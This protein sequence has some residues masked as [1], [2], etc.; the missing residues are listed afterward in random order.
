MGLFSRMKARH[1]R[2]RTRRCPAARAVMP[3]TAAPLRARHADRAALPRGH[4]SSPWSGLG[5]FW[6]A[7]R[8]FWQAEGV[9]T[10]AVG[11]AGGLHAQPDLRGGLLR[12]H[13]AQRGRARGVRPRGDQLRD[14]PARSSGRATTPPR[15]CGRA[16]TWAPSTARASTPTRTTQREIAEAS[17]DAYQQRLTEA[18]LRP[19]HHRDRRR[20]RLLLRRGLPPAV[21]GQ[22][23]ERLLRPGRHRRHLPGGRRRRTR[24]ACPRPGVP[25][26]RGPSLGMKISR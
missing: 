17:R 2:P 8:I 26:Y 16:T 4:S 23:A 25:S 12:A 14:H 18:G 6:G 11:Y 21:P 22:G 9:H 24:G 13:R 10:T 7:E 19:D 15:A 1:A 3:V 5:C 20:A